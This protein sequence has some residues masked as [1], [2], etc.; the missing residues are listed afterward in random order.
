MSLTL[1]KPYFRAG[2]D[3]LGLYEWTDG[4]PS[5]NIPST[6]VEESYQHN[7]EDIS[8]EA[9]GS[10]DHGFTVTYLVEVFFNGY[11]D[12]KTNID[13]AVSRGEDIV[14]E[15]CNPANYG[16]NVQRVEL[17]SMTIVPLSSDFNDNI[18]KVELRFGV[19]V[20]VCF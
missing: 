13:R 8:G 19:R 9:L 12:V 20:S 16:T 5:D 14:I 3:S 17:N 10:L 18:I 4:F 11:R 1:I 2:L 6:L 7:I 15:L